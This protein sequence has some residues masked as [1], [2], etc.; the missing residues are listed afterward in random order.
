LR[1][2]VDRAAQ[3]GP[4]LPELAERLSVAGVRMHV[5]LA[6][7]GRLSGLSFE[8]AGVR[9]K[10]SVLGRDYAWR[11]LAGRHG[12]SYQP[13]RDRAQLEH[14]AVATRREGRGARGCRARPGGPAVARV[15]PAAAPVADRG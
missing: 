11:V 12:I 6:S 8:I 9:W 15:E 5:N 3:G 1:E 7:T 13:A 10:G 2:T 4:T 14:L